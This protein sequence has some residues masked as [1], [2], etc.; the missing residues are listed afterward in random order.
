MNG[1]PFSCLFFLMLGLHIASVDTYVEDSFGVVV[2]S[3]HA[4][5]VFAVGM[6]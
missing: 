6:P 4:K 1:R 5:H 3:W 2:D